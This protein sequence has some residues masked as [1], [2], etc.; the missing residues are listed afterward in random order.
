MWEYSEKVKDYFFNPKNAGVLED[1]SGVGEVGA[2]ACGDALK[3]MIKVDPE[4]DRITEAKFQTFGCGSAIASSS[5]LTEIIIG[6][7]L[8]EALAITNQD[9]ADFLG[10]LPPEKMHCSVMGY[11]ALRSAI[12]NY[13]GEVWEDDHEEG[14]L[15]CKCFGVDEGMVERAIRNNVLTTMEQVAH[16]T[17]ATGSCGTCVEGIEEVLERTNAAMVEAGELAASQAFVVGAAPVVGRK[18]P[19]NSPVVALT[20]PPATKMTTLQRIKLIEAELEALRPALQSDGGD[21][22][23]VDVEDNKV[24]VRLTGACVN[25]QLASVTVQG[26]QSRL[27]ER[28]GTPVRVIPVPSGH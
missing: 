14:A 11:E 16:F 4:T 3:L 12:A 28:L 23:L 27:A 2:I 15:L 18:T 19:R 9:I 1:A 7:T 20:S 5:A 6:K 13:R 26:I 25:C 10:G 21:C 8:D 22:E 24:M 17:K